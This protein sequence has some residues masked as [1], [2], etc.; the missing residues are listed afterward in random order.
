MFCHPETGRPYDASRLR[1]R[2][3]AAVERAGVREVRFHDLR[4]TFGTAMAAAGAPLRSLMEWMGHADLSTTLLY[5][6]Y[7]P[8][9]RRR[10]PPL[11][12]RLSALAPIRVPI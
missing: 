4:H 11:P 9:T 2:F 7:S 5:A 6:D 8:R 1:K 3:K 12:R 10:V